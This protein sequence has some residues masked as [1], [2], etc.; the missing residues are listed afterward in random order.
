M[1]T[2]V[3]LTGLFENPVRES[4]SRNIAVQAAAA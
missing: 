3:S 2:L 1:V 4:A